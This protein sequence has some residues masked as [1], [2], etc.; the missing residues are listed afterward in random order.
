MS[1]GGLKEER[2]IVGYIGIVTKQPLNVLRGR[3]DRKLR[4]IWLEPS[5]CRAGIVTGHREREL[6]N[7]AT[8]T[9]F[10]GRR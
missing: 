3:R 9:T 5:R 10:D 2:D 4:S 8:K 7:V 6:V 1:H